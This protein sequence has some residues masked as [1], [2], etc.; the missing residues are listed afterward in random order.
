MADYED[1]EGGLWDA[2]VD[3]E[4]AGEVNK[5]CHVMIYIRIV[6]VFGT[7]VILVKCKNDNTS[8]GNQK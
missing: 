5:F 4:M 2:G 8:P 7:S 6:L 3:E 1:D